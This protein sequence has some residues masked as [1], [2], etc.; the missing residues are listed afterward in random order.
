MKLLIHCASPLQL[1][2]RAL[3]SITYA[4]VKLAKGGF[5]KSILLRKQRAFGVVILAQQIP[6]KF[7]QL[8]HQD[9]LNVRS[10]LVLS[11]VGHKISSQRGIN[12]QDT[13]FY[14]GQFSGALE[15]MAEF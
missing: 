8:S 13:S 4:Q 5:R 2:L 15:I 3:G 6:A 14:P 9:K 12:R 1:L 11:L 7:L 10:Q